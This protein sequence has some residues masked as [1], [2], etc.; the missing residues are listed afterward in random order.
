MQATLNHT[1]VA[2]LSKTYMYEGCCRAAAV[3]KVVG[4]ES[5]RGC[6]SELVASPRD[7]ARVGASYDRKCLTVHPRSTIL[8]PTLGWHCHALVGA[9]PTQPCLP[10]SKCVPTIL[11]AVAWP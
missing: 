5:L 2:R 10:R 7:G 3:S 9:R 4:R 8:L 11:E 1:D 6:G